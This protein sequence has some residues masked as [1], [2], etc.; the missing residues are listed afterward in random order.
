MGCCSAL[1]NWTHRGSKLRIWK[2]RY[3][4]L[5]TFCTKIGCDFNFWEMWA[6]LSS[7]Q[8]RLSLNWISTTHQ[9]N[10]PMNTAKP[11]LLPTSLLHKLFPKLCCCGLENVYYQLYL[12]LTLGK[13]PS[14]YEL[15]KN[16][17]IF[18]SW[19]QQ[20]PLSAAVQA[21]RLY[22]NS[23]GKR[24]LQAGNWAGNLWVQHFPAQVWRWSICWHLATQLCTPSYVW[25]AAPLQAVYYDIFKC[26]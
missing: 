5:I 20:T 17:G 18:E 4:K 24:V 7:Y 2:W 19:W 11:L 14:A 3:Q 22:L 15:G 21:S 9:N 26:K 12:F 25:R 23:R 8:A 6:L 1:Q 16:P 13:K 10:S